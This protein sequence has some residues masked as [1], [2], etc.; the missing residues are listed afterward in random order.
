LRHYV[1]CCAAFREFDGVR[2]NP[3]AARVFVFTTTDNNKLIEAVNVVRANLI[4][5][6]PCEQQALLELV[7]TLL[8]AQPAA[9]PSNVVA[10]MEVRERRSAVT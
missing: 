9:K 7:D 6:K 3:E 5:K 8:G 2:R 10:Q 4:V 1:R